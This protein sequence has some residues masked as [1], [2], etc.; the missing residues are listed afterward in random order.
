MSETDAASK[1]PRYPHLEGLSGWLILVII[2]L[3]FG[4]IRLLFYVNEAV[5]TLGDPTIKAMLDILSPGLY[6]L[7]MV[8]AA[9]NGCLL[10][11][12]VAL[13]VLFF[14]RDRLFPKVFI[15]VIVFNLVWVV[16]DSLMYQSIFPN[17]PLFD[18]ETT[19]E[20]ASTLVY[21]AIWVPYMLVSK[22]VKVTFT[23]GTYAPR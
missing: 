13:I 1:P 14:K 3:F 17:A 12:Y 10:L 11:A 5:T 2:S 23:T 21:A 6:S 20:F 8:E 18:A 22:R 9:I 15:A 19:R 16:V 7:T 4:M